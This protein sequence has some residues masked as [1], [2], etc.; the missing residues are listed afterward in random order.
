MLFNDLKFFAE[1][2]GWLVAIA[3][4]L[5]LNGDRVAARVGTFIPPLANWLEKRRVE[6][7]VLTSAQLAASIEQEDAAL[8]HEFDVE[9]ANQAHTIRE[10]DRMLTILEKTLENFWTDRQKREDN[11]EKVLTAI[12]DTRMALLKMESTLSLH[13]MTIARQE[14]TLSSLSCVQQTRRLA[15]ARAVQASGKE[16]D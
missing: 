8:H 14:D 3:F 5:V 13:S 11:W 16:S 10:Q 2:F 9:A 7:E 1:N 12:T 15:R 6:K 4:V